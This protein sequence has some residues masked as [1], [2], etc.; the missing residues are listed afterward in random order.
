[1]GTNAPV[2][3]SIRGQPSALSSTSASQSTDW[4]THTRASTQTHRRRPGTLELRAP[5]RAEVSQS[6]LTSLARLLARLSLPG[7]HKAKAGSAPHLHGPQ[8]RSSPQRPDAQL[9]SVRPAARWQGAQL[10][11]HCRLCSVGTLLL[12]SA[13]SFSRSNTRF[14]SLAMPL[15]GLGPRGASAGGG[16]WEGD[17]LARSGLAAAGELSPQGEEAGRS[18]PAASASAGGGSVSEPLG[19]FSAAP[20]PAASAGLAALS[21]AAAAAAGVS[22]AGAAAP[23]VAEVAVAAAAAAAASFSAF[24][25]LVRR[26][27]NQIFTW[28]AQ[29]AGQRPVSGG[30]PQGRIRRRLALHGEGG[31][32]GPADAR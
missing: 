5:P 6:A 20:S 16:E 32:M 3:P 14:S 27:W 9:L 22:V 12:L 13:A 15:R 2:R 8:R 28:G 24:F 19:L 10:S 17:A 25:H 31:L 7:R 26:F 30:M 29:G 4:H 11:A 1:M 18:A 21:P 23:G